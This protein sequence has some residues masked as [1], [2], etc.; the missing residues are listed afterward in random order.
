MKRRACLERMISKSKEDNIQENSIL[1]QSLEIEKRIEKFEK[2]EDELKNITDETKFNMTFEDYVKSNANE[3]DSFIYLRSNKMKYNLPVG[4]KIQKKVESLLK[5]LTIPEKLIPINAVEQSFDNLRNNLI[6]LTSLKKHLDKKEREFI[7]LNHYNNEILN[8]YNAPRILA[9]P[10][11][12]GNN[13]SNLSNINAAIQSSSTNGNLNLAA[14]I[15]NI[16]NPS[17]ITLSLH[18]SNDMSINTTNLTNKDKMKKNIATATAS[19]VGANIHPGFNPQLNQ[20]S[21][22]VN[23]IAIG[24]AI[25][26]TN[27]FIRKV[28]ILQIFFLFFFLQNLLMNFLCSSYFILIRRNI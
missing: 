26:N 8:K 10:S 9:G 3:N 2:F 6:I 27:K 25:S 12:Q 5:E 7:K 23:L 16:N 20:G 24:G 21:S 28:N 14:G 11:Q 1:K 18:E 4:E 22:N 15:G 13:I 19:S 17:N